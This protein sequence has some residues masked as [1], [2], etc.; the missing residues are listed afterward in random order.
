VAFDYKKVCDVPVETSVYRGTVLNFTQDLKVIHPVMKQLI[1]LTKHPVRTEGMVAD[2]LGG[3]QVPPLERGSSNAVL[4]PAEMLVIDASGRLHVQNEVEDIENIHRFGIP[5]P[6]PA[7][8]PEGGP[9][10]APGPGAPFN[11]LGP[12]GDG[13]PR[14]KRPTKG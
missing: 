12:G 10:A 14:S 9:G 13:P 11:P 2:L 3:E 6:P 7:V 8:T 1:E 4:A 5:K